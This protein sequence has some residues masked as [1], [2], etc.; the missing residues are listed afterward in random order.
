MLGV[1]MKCMAMHPEASA[2]A[3]AFLDMIRSRY[4]PED[5]TFTS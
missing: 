5:E 2:L 4:S 3:P 1:C